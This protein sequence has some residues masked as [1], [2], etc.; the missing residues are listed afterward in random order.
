MNNKNDV[1]A[2]YPTKHTDVSSSSIKV[3]EQTLEIKSLDV[4][5]RQRLAHSVIGYL[6][7]LAALTCIF[8]IYW[9]TEQQQQVTES[10]RR[11]SLNEVETT[12]S[13]WMAIH[14][15]VY[16]LTDF[17]SRH[18]GGRSNIEDNCNTDATT[19]YSIHHPEN[20]ILALE[21]QTYLGELSEDVN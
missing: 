4:Y 2:G 9:P 7:V 11:I 10:T 20:M 14:G 18:P 5:K 19:E 13:C 15:K 8:I 6:C 21:P 1:E 12:D 16:D 17:A 3:A